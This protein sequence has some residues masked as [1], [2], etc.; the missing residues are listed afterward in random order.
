MPIGRGVFWPTL[1]YDDAQS[2]GRVKYGVAMMQHL[3][4]PIPFVHCVTAMLLAILFLQSGLDKVFQ[5]SDN[6][7][8]L[9]G[10]FSKTPLRHHVKAMLVTITITEVLTGVMA[11]VGV[12]QIAVNPDAR[13]STT[14]AMYGA[15]LASIDILLLFFGQRIAKDYAGAAALIPYFILC[16]GN[17]LVLTLA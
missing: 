10:H 2:V 14:F 6:L 9:K 11:L 1:I 13:A 8:W 5:F 16:V 17:I 3:L 4:N 12:G 7:H 15:Q